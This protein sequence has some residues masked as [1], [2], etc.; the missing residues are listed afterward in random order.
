MSDTPEAVVVRVDLPK[1]KSQG[2]HYHAP[3]APCGSHLTETY[4]LAV[5]DLAENWDLS[6]CAPCVEHHDLEDYDARV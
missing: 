6:P 4:H 5:D 3:G 2:D 1:K